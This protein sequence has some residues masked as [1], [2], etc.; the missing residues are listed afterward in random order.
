MIYLVYNL[1]QE[2]QRNGYM[3]KRIHV[4]D[5]HL[6]NMFTVNNH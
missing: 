6:R 1:L 2:K 3:L 5:T 4:T